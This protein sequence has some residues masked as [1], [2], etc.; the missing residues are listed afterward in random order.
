MDNASTVWNGNSTS[1]SGM[2]QNN[3][4]CTGCEKA[5]SG[6]DFP[7]R[8]VMNFDYKLPFDTAKFLSRVPSRVTNGW[9]VLSIISAQSGFPFTVNSPYGTQAYGTDEYIGYQA[10]RPDL[11]QA[12]PLRSSGQ[13]EEQFFASSVLQN[14]AQYLGTPTVILP[15]GSE[16]QT[17]PGNLGRNTFRTNPF[18]NFDFSLLKDTRITESKTLQFRAEFFNLF[19]QH[20][21]G[22]PGEVLTSPQFGIATS[23]VL[24]EREIQFGL[25]FIF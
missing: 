6:F 15:N 19:N 3:P 11:I 20:A 16:V 14:S 10:T 1:N 24:A 25:R 7:Q 23:T 17:A 22:I 5:V 18:S 4:F 21:F 2:L 13:P 9:H 12:P 8:F